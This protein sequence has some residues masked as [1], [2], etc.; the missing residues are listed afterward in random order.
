MPRNVMTATVEDSTDWEQKFRSHRDLFR[1]IWAGPVPDFHLATT[2]ENEVA[3]C[4]DVDDVE[5]WWAMQQ[6][7]EIAEAMKKDGVR[8][9]TVKIF[10]L[11][12]TASF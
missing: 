9:D 5:A 1:S 2:E 4:F 7:P 12:R 8:R 11:D 10:V 6:R 3:L